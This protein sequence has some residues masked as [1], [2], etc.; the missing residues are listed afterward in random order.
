MRQIAA[1]SWWTGAADWKPRQ[2]A[3]A[4]TSGKKDGWVE[5]GLPAMCGAC[6][7]GPFSP[8]AGGVQKECPNQVRDVDAP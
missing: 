2:G 3:I 5:I 7:W 6:H 8:L 4:L 1:N